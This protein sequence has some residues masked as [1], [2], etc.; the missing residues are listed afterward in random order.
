MFD[1]AEGPRPDPQALGRQILSFTPCSGLFLGQWD[2]GGVMLS[3]GQRDGSSQPYWGCARRQ[4]GPP[5]A[6][7]QHVSSQALVAETIAKG[8]LTWV[9]L[10]TSSLASAL[11]HLHHTLSY[12]VPQLL[13]FPAHRRHPSHFLTL[14]SPW[15]FHTFTD[16]CPP[17]RSVP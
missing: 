15:H 7:G 4:R 9:L 13:L 2:V 5:S 10:A 11:C 3:E 16:I 14:L 1:E 8:T 12:A 17:S 6:L